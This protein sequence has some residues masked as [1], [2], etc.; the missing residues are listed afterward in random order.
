M[1]YKSFTSSAFPVV[2]L[3]STLATIS[4]VSGDKPKQHWKKSYGNR[5]EIPT[6]GKSMYTYSH[7]LVMHYLDYKALSYHLR[8]VSP[9]L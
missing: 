4:S 8:I 6:M 5:L 3:T 9:Q 2:Q 1:L 7:T